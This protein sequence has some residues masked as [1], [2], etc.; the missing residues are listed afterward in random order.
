MWFGKVAVIMYIFSLSLM[1]AGYFMETTLGDG[2][3]NE[4]S[5][6]AQ[7]VIISNSFNPDAN[8]SVEAIFGDFIAGVKVLFGIMT[9]QTIADAFMLFPAMSME[10]LLLIRVL[11]T[12]SSIFLWIFIVTG[13]S[14]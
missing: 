2:S 7:L 8:I 11:F 6:Y 4:D 3:F 12:A 13:R 14:V 9:G 5:L 1:F 10:W